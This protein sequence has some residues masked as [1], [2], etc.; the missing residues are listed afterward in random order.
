[1]G[2]CWWELVIADKPLT[3]HVQAAMNPGSG[4]HEPIVLNVDPPMWEAG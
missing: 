1:M 2:Y 3:T 4:G